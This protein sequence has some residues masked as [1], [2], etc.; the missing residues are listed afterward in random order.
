MA[1]QSLRLAAQSMQP[2]P[3]KAYIGQCMNSPKRQMV[4][5]LVE[6]SFDKHIYESRLNQSDIEV[7]IAFDDS[8]HHNRNSVEFLT[9]ELRDNYP[10]GRF[11]GIRDKDY[12]PFLGQQVPVGVIVTDHRDIEMTI[13]SSSDTVAAIPDLAL[14]LPDVLQ[15]CFHFGHIRIFAESRNLRNKV[16]EKLKIVAIYDQ[17]AKLYV[18][19]V[20]G[21]LR[22]NYFS[23]VDSESNCAEL[24]SFIN[25]HELNKCSVYDVCRG[26]DVVGLLE[27]VYGNNFS[28]TE[29]ES[30]MIQNYPAGTFYQTNMFLQI[31]SYCSQFGIDAKIINENNLNKA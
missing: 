12:L 13:L 5:C 14:C 17:K 30:Q 27:W 18:S 16:N 25:L 28:R 15:H 31:E 21:H 20:I 2:Q 22:S 9:G 7:L 8:L 24:D 23:K 29:L 19:D 3:V 4:F 6:G 26:H 1:Q 10:A 11:I